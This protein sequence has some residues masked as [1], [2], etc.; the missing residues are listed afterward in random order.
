MRLAGDHQVIRSPLDRCERSRHQPA[1][2]QRVIELR[3]GAG[4]QWL[5]ELVV[6]RQLC[7]LDKHHR[8]GVM[9]NKGSDHVTGPG[10]LDLSG[11]S[12]GITLGTGDTPHGVSRRSN[13]ATVPS[14]SIG[15]SPRTIWGSSLISRRRSIRSTRL[16]RSA[17]WSSDICSSRSSSV[18]ELA[19]DELNSPHHASVDS[20][21]C[22]AP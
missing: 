10:D 3:H 14:L 22:R 19:V 15:D 5:L 2:D 6:R 18:S 4:A 12:L 11:S 7:T 21:R 9:I 16:M 1:L 8:S 13:V 17:I 20:P